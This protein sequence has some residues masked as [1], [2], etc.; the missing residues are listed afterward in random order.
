M[1]SLEEQPLGNSFEKVFIGNAGTATSGLDITEVFST[2]LY[3]GNG[4]SQTIVN[5]I[6]LGG[7]GRGTSTLFDGGAYLNRTSDLANNAD[8]KTLT[9]S[10]WVFPE[11]DANQMFFQAA[12]SNG[13]GRVVLSLD[14]T[15][16]LAFGLWN[17]SGGLILGLESRLTSGGGLPLKVWSHVL[18]SVD[19]ANT[20]NRHLYINDAIPSHVD[21]DTYTD[22][23]VDFTQPKWGIAGSPTSGGD[24]ERMAHLY[25]DYTFRDLSTASNRRIFIDA[26]GGSTAPS[27]LAAL[28]PI[29]YVP[30]TED[31]T[32]GKNIGTGG[33]FTANGSPTI[34]QS[35]TQYEDDY[36]QG[37]LVWTKSRTT[38][39]AHGLYDT[40]RGVSKEISSSSAVAQSTDNGVTAFNSNGYTVGNRHTTNT[41]AANYASWT[42]R[43]APKFFDVVTYTGSGSAKTVAHSLGSAPGMIIIKNTGVSDPWAV[44]H[45]ANTAAPQTDYLVLNTTAATVDS[46]AWWNDT[47]PTSSVFTVGTDHSVNANGENYVAYLF[48]HND[49]DGEFGPDADQDIIKCGVYTGNGS[50]DGPEIDLGFEPQWMITKGADRG[51]YW[52]M[53]DNM[54]GWDANGNWQFLRADGADAESA[55]S[56][57]TYLLKSTGFKV[58]STSNS[59]NANGESYI[60]MAIRRGPLAPP[61]AAT[62]VFNT[63]IGSGVQSPGFPVDF[64]IGLNDRTSPQSYDP[65]V[66]T[67]LLGGVSYLT[68]SITAGEASGSD[69][70]FDT[71]DG[72]T[73]SWPNSNAI[74]WY[75]KRAPNYFDVVT[76]TGTGSART[77]SHNV[78]GVAP[79]MM[80]IKRRDNTG[81]WAVYHSGVDT[82]SPED[83]Y[84][85]LNETDTRDNDARFWNDTAPTDTVF[86]VG[87]HSQVNTSGATYIS[88]LFSSL[89]GISKVG[90][91]TGNGS[92][93]TIDCGFSNGARLILIKRTDSTSDWALFDS[94]RGIV[95]GNSPMRKL[96]TSSGEINDEDIVDPI[97]SG[98]IVNSIENRINVSD[99]TYIFYAIA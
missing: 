29:I 54:S 12:T 62:E 88:Y 5:G 90:S 66:K 56:A 82:N 33:D 23:T 96:N 83:F 72:L 13:S 61:E 64:L 3:T 81:V 53:L 99:A 40:V 32:I 11:E 15:Q 75:W 67:R 73:Y 34:L 10:V 43:K 39:S 8:G 46:A 20:S 22:D 27:T 77:V 21:W 52:H 74:A 35:G 49:G 6:A 86:T 44:Y 95:S 55:G 78:L 79:E 69:V 16:K 48:A 91:Y 89:D 37:G 25:F 97:S 84:M 98:F 51:S 19:L 36:G 1:V 87:T 68:T 7:F 63:V 47:A 59:Y 80:W 28:N 14:D 24:D 30:M 42:F 76:Y 92:S 50:T 18:I 2:Y 9:L 38:A 70:G 71:M 60:Y 58:N 93:Q 17:S 41:S 85:L 4:A 94:A 26:N 65:F 45:R 31:Y 57:N